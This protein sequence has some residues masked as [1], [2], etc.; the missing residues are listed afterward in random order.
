VLCY[1]IAPSGSKKVGDAHRSI[2]RADGP[3]AR[4]RR[5]G[6]RRKTIASLF[7]FFF[8]PLEI[9]SVAVLA[10]GFLDAAYGLRGKPQFF[11]DLPVTLARYQAIHSRGAQHQIA[12]LA[13]GCQRP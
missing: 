10:Y 2:L 9:A 13:G 4:S 7:P 5:E 1:S 3:A 6:L 12:P 8:T 11:A